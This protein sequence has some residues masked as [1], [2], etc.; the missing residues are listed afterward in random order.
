MSVF[1][2]DQNFFDA[3]LSIRADFFG[4]FAPI[5]TCHLTNPAYCWELAIVSSVC[6]S[7]SS[8]NSTFLLT[9]NGSLTVGGLGQD[10]E[11]DE[12]SFRSVGRVHGIVWLRYLAVV[13]RGS[14]LVWIEPLPYRTHHANPGQRRNPDPLRTTGSCFGTRSL[15]LDRAV[16]GQFPCRRCE[17]SC[18]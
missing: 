9:V 16:E 17:K 13:R 8:L 7:K 2:R 12:I 11:L 4:F 3:K 6:S 14:A 1:A 15:L 5:Y 18:F 10:V